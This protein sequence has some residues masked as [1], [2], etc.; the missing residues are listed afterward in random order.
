MLPYWTRSRCLPAVAL[1]RGSLLPRWPRELAPAA[2]LQASRGSCSGG[3]KLPWA[4]REQSPK[5]HP[6][7]PKCLTAEPPCE[8]K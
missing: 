4:K 6:R 8:D 2:L 5:G 1:E 3:S 7:T